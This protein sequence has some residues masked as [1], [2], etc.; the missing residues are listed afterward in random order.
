MT[1]KD[2]AARNKRWFVS[3]KDVDYDIERRFGKLV[4]AAR[5]NSFSSWENDPENGLALVILLDQFPRNLFRGKARA[6]A[7]DD[8]ALSLTRKMVEKGYLSQLGYPERAFALM[9][10]QHVESLDL[11]QEGVVLYRE[12]AEA[13]PDDWKQTMNG[14]ADFA[15][16]H[17]TI[18]ERFGRFPHRNKALG[19]E[20][21]AVETE[22]LA[23]GGSRFGQ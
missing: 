20:N 3:D 1:P 7:S 4:N 13:A 5:S 19:R 15:D 11:Q 12:Q 2:V 6:F 18:I 22:Y 9:P 16:Q 17:C 23:S 14:Y 10:Y 21:T 8:K